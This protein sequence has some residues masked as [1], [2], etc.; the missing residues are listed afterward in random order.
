MQLRRLVPPGAAK[1][2]VKLEGLNPTGSMKDRMAVAVIDR[3]AADGR[4]KPGDSFSQNCAWANWM[5]AVAGH[6]RRMGF[7]N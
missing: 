4:L 3:A 2:F 1:V 5:A 6:D 7:S